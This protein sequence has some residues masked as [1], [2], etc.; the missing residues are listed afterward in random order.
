MRNIK[1]RR[2]HPNWFSRGEMRRDRFGGYV[3]YT[4]YCQVVSKYKQEISRLKE[5][6]VRT[7]MKEAGLGD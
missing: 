1:I 2:F 5:T 3:P 6:I 7:R 4:D